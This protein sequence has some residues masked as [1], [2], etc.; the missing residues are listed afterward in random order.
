[1]VYHSGSLC[2]DNSWQSN[3]SVQRWYFDLRMV[4]PQPIGI[5]LYREWMSTVK[6][7]L[8]LSVTY[9]LKCEWTFC[10]N[11]GTRWKSKRSQ[12]IY[13][14]FYKTIN[15]WEVSEEVHSKSRLAYKSTDWQNYITFIRQ[16]HRGKTAD[17]KNK[18]PKTKTVGSGIIC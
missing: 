1:M 10:S 15:I 9:F 11:N 2:P 18:S 5:S 13:K 17:N 16:F 6:G 8:H 12:I 3:S 4:N 7:T 14:I